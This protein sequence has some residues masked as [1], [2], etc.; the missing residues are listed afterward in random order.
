M[1]ESTVSVRIGILFTDGQPRKFMPL[2]QHEIAADGAAFEAELEMVRREMIRPP[3]ESFISLFAELDALVATGSRQSLQ[4]L[5][6]IEPAA[7]RRAA[8]LRMGSIAASMTQVRLYAAIAAQPSVQTICEIGFN[9]GHSTAVWL[10]SN[11]HATVESFDLYK[12][13]ASHAALHL[14]QQRFP[15]RLTAHR[16][17]SLSTVARARLPRRCDLVHVDGR[18]SFRHVVADALNMIPLAAPTA[19]FLF[20]DQCR[21]SSCDAGSTVAGEPTLATCELENARFLQVKATN[22]RLIDLGWPLM[23][24]TP[25]LSLS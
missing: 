16:G 22:G 9:A 17:D 2:Y 5:Q 10:S 21:A 19:I 8:L 13:R 12:T 15:G 23:A 24:F 20:D 25:S 3:N 18:H 14:L 7:Q 6:K 1:C 4:S 11:K